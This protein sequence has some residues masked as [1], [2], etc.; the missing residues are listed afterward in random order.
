MPGWEHW[1]GSASAKPE[2]V[3]LDRIHK[4]CRIHRKELAAQRDHFRQTEP[5]VTLS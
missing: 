5:S 1:R 4:I 3:F 2:N